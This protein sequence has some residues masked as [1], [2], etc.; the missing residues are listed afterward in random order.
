MQLQTKCIHFEVCF[1]VRNNRNY[2]LIFEFLNS[3]E[4]YAIENKVTL[5]TGRLVHKNEWMVC[6]SVVSNLI[7]V[8]KTANRLLIDIYLCMNKHQLIAHKNTNHEKM[9][10]MN[11]S[12][13]WNRF[14]KSNDS[15]QA[16]I[17][18][19]LSEKVDCTSTIIGLVANHNPFNGMNNNCK[20]FL[21]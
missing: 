2:D 13:L 14:T 10:V 19:I 7:P 15:F 20:N 16:S 6:F 5:C 18:F 11:F 3:V 12:F 8:T 21:R 1:F 17:Q 9:I 4:L